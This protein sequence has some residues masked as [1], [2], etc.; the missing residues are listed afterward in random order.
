MSPAAVGSSTARD[1]LLAGLGA[2]LMWGLVPLYWPLLE[3]AGALEIL[4][5]R[6]VWSLAVVGVLTVVDARRR[7]AGLLGRTGQFGF[8]YRP[9]VAVLLTVAAVLVSINWGVYIWAVNNDHVVDASLGYFINPLVSVA[10][11]VLVLRERLR[12]LQWAALAIATAGV[13]ELTVTSGTVPLTALVLAG[14]FG[15]Y[16]LLKKLADAPAVPALTFET[17]VLF[18]PAVAFLAVLGAS[19]GG[20]FADLGTGHRLLL[21]S[22]GV[23][24]AVPLVLFGAAA[25]RIPLSSLGILQYLTPTMQFLLGVLA[26]REHL[27]GARLLGFVV[28]W[29]ALAL[30]TVD[31]LGRSRSGRSR[32]SAVPDGQGHRDRVQRVAGRAG[33]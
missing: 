13:V 32:V 22:T 8:L 28:I 19:G 20:T 25:V 17:A 33:R 31:A 12:R 15:L 1:G 6:M 14:S 5:H 11:G 24:T 27:S 9:G 29:T 21:A 2:Y 7:H 26:F 30:F 4:A 23:V 3:P 18:P 16:G 10:L